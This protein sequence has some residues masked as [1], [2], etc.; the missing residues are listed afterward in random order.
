MF[1]L[2]CNSPIHLVCELRDPAKLKIMILIQ[3]GFIYLFCVFVAVLLRSGLYCQTEFYP[4]ISFKLKLLGEV[5][6][7]AQFARI[8][9]GKK[10]PNI[11]WSMH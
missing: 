10:Y 5:L 11:T 3:K 7:M 1:H 6:C 9:H 4:S 2:L 8:P